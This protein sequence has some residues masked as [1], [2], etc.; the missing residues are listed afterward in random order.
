MH[1]RPELAF[2][3]GLKLILTQ[4]FE[5]IW[6]LSTGPPPDLN[7][8]L[9]IYSQLLE[10]VSFPQVR[11]CWGKHVAVSRGFCKYGLKKAKVGIKKHTENGDLSHRGQTCS[12]DSAFFKAAICPWLAN[13]IW[14]P[15]MW[16]GLL[17]MPISSLSQYQGFLGNGWNF[18]GQSVDQNRVSK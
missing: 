2:I 3:A 13:P 18:I 14:N 8:T 4:M 9:Y 15:P 5:P 17:R 11:R 16:T 7:F 1:L 10:A 6:V 12:D